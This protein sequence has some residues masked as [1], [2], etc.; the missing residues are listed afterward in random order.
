MTTRDAL[1]ELTLAATARPLTAEEQGAAR[2]LLEQTLWEELE[3]LSQ[4]DLE[5]LLNDLRTASRQ[6]ELTP[7]ERLQE[8]LALNLLD[9]ALAEEYGD[10][11]EWSDEESRSIEEAACEETDGYGQAEYEADDHS[12]G[13]ARWT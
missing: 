1:N 3:A 6:R 12:E 2:L 13:T 10:E 9:Q 8:G 11:E 4:T 7:L 5:T